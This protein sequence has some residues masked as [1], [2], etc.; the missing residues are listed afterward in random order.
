[1]GDS[2]AAGLAQPDGALNLAVIPGMEGVA[3]ALG[4]ALLLCLVL[5]FLINVKEKS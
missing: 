2:A 1:M 3:L 5:A 4:L